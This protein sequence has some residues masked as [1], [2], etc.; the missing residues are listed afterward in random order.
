M[1]KALTIIIFSF[2]C[3]FTQAQVIIHL[4]PANG[5][6][7]R[8]R[9]HVDTLWV[10][11][12]HEH[13][14]NPAGLRGSA[15]ADFMLLLQQ[16]ADD[17]IKSAGMSK[18]TFE[19]L[20]KDSLSVHEKWEIVKPYWEKS[21][22]T[23][24]NRAV[25]VTLQ[26]IFGFSELS[27]KTVAPLSQKIRDAYESNDFYTYILKDKSR[28]RYVINDHPD[29]SWGDPEIF[30]Y[31]QRFNY[32]L[33]DSRVKVEAIG[34]QNGITISTLAD[35]E[36]SLETDFENALSKG[37]A[38]IKSAE[39][40]HR[41]LYYEDVTREKA[42]HVFQ[43]IMG[44]GNGPVSPEEAK[45][46]SDYMMHRILDL[47]CKYDKPIQIHTGLHAGDGNYIEN[48]N[49]THLANLLLKYRDVRFVLLHGS[50]PYGGEAA[51]LA[52]NFR[53]VFLDMSWVHI[54]SP[55]FSER[56]LHE[57]LETVPAG[58]IMAFG[59][60]YDNIENVYA[61]LYFARQIIANVLTEKVRSRYLSEPEAIRIA[62]M[63]L[64]ENAVD[65][66]KLEP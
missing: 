60:D 50:Y 23:A 66:Y 20:L 49:P 64:Y 62:S 35:L 51:T 33:L 59:G 37:F 14:S 58:K 7:N 26:H 22:N 48:S 65:F 40:Y 2:F 6:E 25:M 55:S 10:V 42:V 53:N 36:K 29:R 12:T 38:A 45:T 5:F 57:W 54:I 41:S 17:D 8:I 56:Y 4:A 34:K 27:D 52:K 43:T 15:K 19:M 9:E 31:T 47:A 13:L 21:A 63:L 24:Y 44:S 61:H 28:I 1:N 11:D 3:L 30:R 32:L 18:P 16:Y 46:L 39:A